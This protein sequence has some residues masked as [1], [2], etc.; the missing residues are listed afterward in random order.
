LETEDEVIWPKVGKIV[1]VWVQVWISV[2][3]PSLGKTKE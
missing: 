3:I 1:N 2:P